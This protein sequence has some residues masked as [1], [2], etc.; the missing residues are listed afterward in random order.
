MDRSRADK[1]IAHAHVIRCLGGNDGSSKTKTLVV[2]LR[3]KG[4][5]CLGNGGCL[6][7]AMHKMLFEKLFLPAFGAH[8]SCLDISFVC[9]EM[10]SMARD[11]CEP[12]HLFRNAWAP[13]DGVKR[14]CKKS[15]IKRNE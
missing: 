15:N 11:R 2:D 3:G 5:S 6:P 14:G 8:D 13:P 12:E 7:I 9:L 10:S 4:S 1:G